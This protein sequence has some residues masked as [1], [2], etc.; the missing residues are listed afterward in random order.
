[1]IQGGKAARRK[2][3]APS[4]VFPHGDEEWRNAL[5]L[6]RPTLAG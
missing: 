1:V 5:T 4:A 3:M 6:F 2:S